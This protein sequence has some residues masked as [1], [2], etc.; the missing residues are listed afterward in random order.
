M[1]QTIS[2]VQS[3]TL[4]RHLIDG[5]KVESRET[6]QTLNPSTNEP[7]ADVA[8]GGDDEIDA[9]VRA[10]KTAFPA[11][12]SMPA[13]KRSKLMLRLAELID[14]D[15]EAIARLESADTGQSYARTRNLLIPRAAD[16][17]RFFADMCLHVDGHTY[18]TADHLNY[19]IYQ[20][21][22]V[23]GLISPWNIP[24]MT[25]TWKAAPCLAFGNTAVL[26]MSELSPLSADRL[27]ELALEAGI[28]A[29]VLNVVHGYGRTAGEALARHPD[30]RGISFTGSTKT[31]HRIVQAGGLKKYSM[32]LGGKSPFIV[33]E[34]ADLDRALDAALI[35]IYGNNGESCTAGSRI[36]LQESIH[37][38]FVERFVERTNN[39]KVGD[40]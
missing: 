9:A 11:W 8:S 6:F 26:K 3:S 32:E 7:I 17:F 5:R 21:V 33:F 27:G 24:F 19:T 36:L 20:P 4:I 13:P 22:G 12:A 18:P 15:V 40:P 31:G 39:I 38:A 2:R 35:T 29:G 23:F 34:D 10:A 25:A 30:V 28:P 1:D 14:E 37:D 16:N